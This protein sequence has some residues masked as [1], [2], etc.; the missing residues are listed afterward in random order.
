MKTTKQETHT[1]H[2][3][4][5]HQHPPMP[6]STAAIDAIT[7]THTHPPPNPLLR[8]IQHPQPLYFIYNY[9]STKDWGNIPTTKTRHTD[10]STHAYP[11]A[12]D[13]VDAITH[14]R[15]RPSPNPLLGTFHHFQT[16][17]FIYN[18]DNPKPT[19]MLRDGA[20]CLDR[21]L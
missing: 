13:A 12:L 14:T 3:N 4:S 9:N 20:Q 17:S 7:H 18:Y 2:P 1:T 11:P 6:R 5:H 16:L 15:T 10:T 21:G 8:T 19:S